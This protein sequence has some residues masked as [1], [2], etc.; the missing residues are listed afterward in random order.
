MTH[1]G[2]STRRL[3]VGFLLAFL[4]RIAYADPSVPWTPTTAARHALE[5]LVDEGGLA[6]P[7]T[8]WPLP[9][10]AVARALD[11]LP[12][13]LK[14]ALDA[15][16][17]RVAA[18][19]RAADAP[20]LS[21]GVRGRDEALSG[22]G[23]ESTPGSWLGGRSGTLVAHGFAAQVG[24]RLDQGTVPSRPEAKLRLDETAIG[25]EIFGTQ[26]QAWA[27]RSWWGPGWQSSLLLGNNAPPFYGIGLQRASAER[28]DSRWLSWMGPWSYEFF[29]AAEDDTIDSYLVG[30]RITMRPFSLLEIGLSRTAQW[31]GHGRPQSFD[32][33]L[34]MLVSRGVNANGPTE[35]AQDPANEMAGFDL[36]LRCGSI[37]PCVFY[38]QLIGENATRGHPSDF[39]GLYGLEAWSANG[40]HRWFAEF[41]ATICGGASSYFPV[42]G[43]AYRNWAYPDGYT[44]AGRWIGSAVG[45]DSRVTTLGWLDVERGTLLRLHYG[46]IGAR[47][48]VYAPAGDLEH[49][50]RMRGIGVRQSWTWGRTTLGAELDAFH[51]DAQQGPQQEARLGVTL[52]VPF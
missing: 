38:A 30:M 48:G 15:A 41:A 13:E 17:E 51:I 5:L 28:S 25:L 44:H 11:A 1:D 26:L 47:V 52:R 32:S 4:C 49:S 29:I 19:L 36:R 45:P 14:P 10:R 21:L 12:R 37:L 42:R 35:Q 43:C 50:G 16:R 3:V 24:A 20:E 27:H 39:L 6:L 7:L 46:S 33:F 40:R 23:D 9:R 2:P 34:R 31:G 22:F 8:H 18:E